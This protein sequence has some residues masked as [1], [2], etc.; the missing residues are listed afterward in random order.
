MSVWKW[1]ARRIARQTRD[2]SFRRDVLEIIE[3]QQFELLTEIVI[4][5]CATTPI[6]SQVIDRLQWI[7]RSMP[8]LEEHRHNLEVIMMIIRCTAVHFVATE[9]V[10]IVQHM[11]PSFVQL[12]FA[13]PKLASHLACITMS[14][15]IRRVDGYDYL[16]DL[17][18]KAFVYSLEFLPMVSMNALTVAL[19]DYNNP[20]VAYAFCRSEVMRYARRNES[21]RSVLQTLLECDE[22]T[23]PMHYRHYVRSK[24]ALLA[25]LVFDKPL[26]IERIAADFVTDRELPSLFINRYIANVVGNHHDRNPNTENFEMIWQGLVS[27]LRGRECNN[28]IFR[29]ILEVLQICSTPI[30]VAVARQLRCISYDDYEED[31]PNL[32]FYVS[33]I[34]RCFYFSFHYFGLLSVDHYNAELELTQKSYEAVNVFRVLVHM[35][36]WSEF[37]IGTRLFDFLGLSKPN[38]R[39]GAWIRQTMAI[40]QY[41]KSM[42]CAVVV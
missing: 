20:L 30:F 37:P 40:G 1:R 22:D 5:L 26:V 42:A 2:V 33:R 12:A 31:T 11:M 32:D 19:V 10:E 4:D 8:L 23:V 6:T 14:R 28:V 35:G 38:I 24:R 27:V 25:F 17:F 13:W 16:N 29:V 36:S 39:S 9:P 3:K 34:P 21:V 18:S 7:D 41:V 15:G